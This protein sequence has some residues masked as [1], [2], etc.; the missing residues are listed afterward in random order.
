MPLNASISTDSVVVEPGTT[1]PLTIEVENSGSEPDQ[2][3]IGIEGIDG[4]WIAIPVPVVDLKA[5]ERQSVK[6]FFKP[7]RVAESTAGNFPFIAKVRSLSSGDQKISQGILTVKAFH[8]L[9]VDLNP[10]KGF[11]TSTKTQNIFAAS[12]INMGNSEHNVQLMADDPENACTY[13][14]DEENV[15]LGP[16][17]QKEVD[18]AV[19]P[20][21]TASLGSARLIGFAVTVRSTDAPGVVASSQAQLEVRPFLTPSTLVG[22]LIMTIIALTVWLTQPKRPTV[23]L[24]MIGNSRKVM[25]GDKVMIH[26]VASNATAVK[27]VSGGEVVGENLPPEG[28]QE[29]DTPLVGTLEVQAVA[30]RDKRQSEVAKLRIVVEEPPVIPEPKILEL[31]PSSV[32]VNKGEKFTLSYKF[33]P[34]VTSAKLAPDNVE[35]DLRLNTILLDPP[36]LGVNEYT[37]I[38]ENSAKKA[39][40]QT[41]KVTVIEPVLAKIVKFE[42]TPLVVDTEDGKV[43]MNWEVTDAAKVEF[44]YTGG[45]SY[46]LDPKGTTEIPI[47]AKTTFTLTVTDVNGKSVKKSITV[48]VKKPSIDP[49]P[50]DP[51]A[52]GGDLRNP[53][54]TTGTTGQ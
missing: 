37:V 14:F 40:K 10:K 13:E 1:A 9:S 6:V 12:L 24:E 43:T 53:P 3:E 32:T 54:T 4:E 28:S 34:E 35:L 2:Y 48:D 22:V 5:G 31:K 52:D 11:V 44:T 36:K 50:S 49:K 38:A 47:V 8:S 26:W 30:F 27:L 29:V 7:P 25:R 41:F 20:K 19:H 21:K 39:V 33:G 42:V 18:F 15:H 51:P 23:S 46:T 17:Q 45:Q 16:G